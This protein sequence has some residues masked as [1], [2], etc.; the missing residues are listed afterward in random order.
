MLAYFS[1]V[2]GLKSNFNIAYKIHECRPYIN[3]PK[4]CF[5]AV[6]DDGSQCASSEINNNNNNA[7]RKFG[8]HFNKIIKYAD[9]G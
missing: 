1:A 6:N 8:G 5:N 4:W 3:S 7:L 2:P 9:F